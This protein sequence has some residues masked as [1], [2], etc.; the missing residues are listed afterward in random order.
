M[1]S[2]L[3]DFWPDSCFL[4]PLPPSPTSSYRDRRT[5]L[6][7]KRRLSDVT[8]QHVQASSS[9]YVC[10]YAYLSPLGSIRPRSV[11]KGRH[12]R[13]CTTPLVHLASTA[14]AMALF[15][16]P[17]PSKANTRVGNIGLSVQARFVNKHV[18]GLLLF[19]IDIF[20]I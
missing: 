8:L 7:Q 13:C 1:K 20:H 2:K 3:V 10:A 19:K 4:D 16:H 14:F 6:Q 12:L 5:T 11:R 15:W 17:F 9:L 18:R